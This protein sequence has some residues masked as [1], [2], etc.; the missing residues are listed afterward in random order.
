[1]SQP[2]PDASWPRGRPGS[3][4]RK[5]ANP[6]AAGRLDAP[7]AGR[8]WVSEPP[9]DRG[10]DEEWPPDA[11]KRDPS[12]KPDPFLEPDPSLERGPSAEPG[13]DREQGPAEGRGAVALTGRGAVA[14]MLVLFFFILLIASWLQWGVLAG[15]SFVIGSVGAAW[16]TKRRDLL[17]VA[18]SP[19][20]LFFFALICV[21]ALT[22]KGS[23]IISTVE[24][25]ALTLANV[26]PW[27]F[28]GVILSLIV[29]WVRGLPQCVADLRRELRPDLAR[30][31]PGSARAT[32]SR[33]GSSPGSRRAR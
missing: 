8:P 10:L 2:R 7:V 18:V 28:A 23:A 22:A 25:T 24:G 19:P 29:A 11:M 27:L 9:A 20:L 21:K 4:A 32:A 12:V 3:P 31:R 6:W 26:A 5:T 1:M 14:G 30:P 15:A 16:Y 33:A 17:T 13:T